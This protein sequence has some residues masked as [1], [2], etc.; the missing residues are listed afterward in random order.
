MEVQNLFGVPVHKQDFPVV[1]LSNQSTRS[2]NEPARN[3]AYYE[4]VDLLTKLKV[5]ESMHD[6]LTHKCTTVHWVTHKKPTR[7]QIRCTS[8][9]ALNELEH[10]TQDIPPHVLIPVADREI[11]L[12]QQL[13]YKIG[14]KKLHGNV[15][16]M[17]DAILCTRDLSDSTQSGQYGYEAL[18][19][20]RPDL[21]I[22]DRAEKGAKDEKKKSKNNLVELIL[23]AV[24]ETTSDQ[25]DEE[26]ETEKSEVC[27]F[28]FIHLFSVNLFL[29]LF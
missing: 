15:V 23:S 6:E 13:A 28:T 5:P 16:V 3:V 26:H 7:M 20:L 14:K 8:H 22:G 4:L 10:K 29:L 9:L 27:L 11:K 19:L 17:N 2:T 1:V 24:P 21:H 18:V 25:P 12:Q